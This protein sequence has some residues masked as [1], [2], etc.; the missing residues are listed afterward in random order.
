MLLEGGVGV[1][2]VA[3]GGAAGFSASFSGAMVDVDVDREKLARGPR[4]V[5]FSFF[6]NFHV[7][8]FAN[9]V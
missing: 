1:L 4:W 6:V 5:S 7:D 8:M 3:A 9:C 2:D